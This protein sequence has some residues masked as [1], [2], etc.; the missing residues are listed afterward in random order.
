MNPLTTF[1]FYRK[2]PIRS[3][4]ILLLTLFTTVGSI[5]IRWVLGDLVDGMGGRANLLQSCLIL[6]AVSIGLA[7]MSTI[8]TMLRERFSGKVLYELYA[9]LHGQILHLSESEKGKISDGELT[10]LYTRDVGQVQDC[11]M[12]IWVRLI[13]DVFTWAAAIAALSLIQIWLGV[14]AVVSAG[15]TFAA[16]FWLSRPIS[17]GTK[18]YQETLD[19]SNADVSSGL[20][21]VETIRT[22]GMISQF[23]KR[24]QND[25]H[26]LQKNKCRVSLWEALLGA[27]ITLASFLTIL[28]LVTLGGFLRM[29]NQIS[30]GELFIVVT[31]IDYTISPVMNLDGTISRIRRA[32]ISRNRINT[33]LGTKTEHPAAV[34]LTKIETVG[35]HQA[36]FAYPG[37]D[38]RILDQVSTEWQSGEINWITGENGIGKSTLAKLL[39]GAYALQGGQILLNGQPFDAEQ[40]MALRERMVVMPQDSFLFAGTVL[41]NL[42]NHR[43]EAISLCQK[44]GI[45]EEIMQ[46]TDGYDTMLTENGANLSGGQKQRLC[47]VRALLQKGELYFFDEPT[48]AIDTSHKKLL[49]QQLQALAKQHIVLVVTHDTEILPKEQEAA[50]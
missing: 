26:Q 39:T 34:S 28:T 2:F 6:L 32:S 11:V 5:S 15:I 19:Q 30:I 27:P 48:A 9:R 35:L 10:T 7:G 31:L 29:Q 44:I 13:P 50:R 45:H 33:F 49:M 12:R 40:L 46:L 37:T 25:L 17:H 21:N 38:Q 20:Y 1:T 8:L 18:Q 22:S 14:V 23:V 16:V 43:E 24:F 42:G 4:L 3:I 36:V 41:E 47:M